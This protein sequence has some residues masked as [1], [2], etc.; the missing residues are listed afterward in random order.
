MPYQLLLFL[1]L[2]SKHILML[3][4]TAVYLKLTS[5]SKE[6]C[7]QCRRLALGPRRLSFPEALLVSVAEPFPQGTNPDQIRDTAI[8]AY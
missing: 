2:L 8:L 4:L 1:A 3:T 7:I 6:K 5:T